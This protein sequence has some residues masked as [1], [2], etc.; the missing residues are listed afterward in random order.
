MQFVPSP[1]VTA[2]W[3]LRRWGLTVRA[4]NDLATRP[5]VQ[6]KSLAIVGNAGYL[7]ELAQGE[8]ID[9]HDLVLRMNNFRVA[10]F[11][12]QVG[13]RT[14][15]FLTTFHSD[16]DLSNPALADA[17]LIVASVPCNFAKSRGRGLQQRHAEF[18]VRGVRQ[19]ERREVFV[20]AIDYFTAARRAI[21]RYP[22]T[23]AMAVLLA[24][25]FLL[26]VCGEIYVT[27]FSFFAGRGHYFH[28]APVAA[29]NHDPGREQALLGERLAPHVSSGRVRLDARLAAQ[30][31]FPARAT[32]SGRAPLEP[33]PP[34]VRL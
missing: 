13:T 4:W 28:G 20:P 3:L 24:L 23:G 16:V 21:G 8:L 26:P 19:M 12:R 10:G 30:L 7:S 34:A 15:I 31:R 27:G 29:N 6:R 14:D 25:D 32:Q 33:A 18:I 2:Y 1:L 5:N 22:S 9:S 17:Q 11:E